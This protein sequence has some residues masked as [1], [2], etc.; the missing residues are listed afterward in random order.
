[1]WGAQREFGFGKIEFFEEDDMIV[2]AK[3]YR[4]ST[5]NRIFDNTVDTFDLNLKSGTPVFFSLRK[6]QKN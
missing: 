4:F 2:D 5:T 3:N 1:M 6:R